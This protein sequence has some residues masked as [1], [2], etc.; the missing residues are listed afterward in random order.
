MSPD[1]TQSEKKHKYENEHAKEATL[2][3][4]IDV[5]H[6]W[7]D[8]HGQ[9]FL[10][11]RLS[12]A[13]I[14]TEIYPNDPNYYFKSHGLSFSNLLTLL[15]PGGSQTSGSTVPDPAAAWAFRSA[16]FAACRSSTTEPTAR[17]TASTAAARSQRAGGPATECPVLP[18]G[19]RG[20]GQRLGI[21]TWIRLLMVQFLN[22][23]QKND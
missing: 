19:G 9:M 2:G 18:S 3:W 7:L 13:G 6:D 10:C 15:H 11:W 20:R 1:I 21:H 8:P 22:G 23:A 17:S 12:S 14:L 4:K 5:Q 16:L